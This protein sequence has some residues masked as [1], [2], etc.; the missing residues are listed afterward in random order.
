MIVRTEDVSD[1]EGVDR[2]TSNAILSR[3]A[4]KGWLQRL[5]R[6]KYVVIPVGAA[7]D[8]PAVEFAWHIAAVLYDPCMVSGWSA[9]EHWGL[10]D[11]IFNVVSIVTAKPQRTRNQNVGGVRFRIR[12]LPE[13]KIFGATNVWFG[14]AKARVADAHRTLID[15]F[16]VPDLGGGG[17]HVVDIA[18][19]YWRSRYADDDK[20]LD[21]AERFGR[22]T[23][24][25][26]LG[27]MAEQYGTASEEWI[28]RCMAGC[29]RGVSLFDPHAPRTGPIRSRWQI[30]VN[31]PLAER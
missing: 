9:A 28:R 1:I 18:K 27:L 31:I 3:L 4:K 12:T 6:G 30:R 26:R 11:Q 23:V 25:K 17:R 5:L 21:Y 24:F 8:T 10:T 22:G 20:L 7:T 16:D 29:S 2:S 14:S 13:E 19:E 15:I